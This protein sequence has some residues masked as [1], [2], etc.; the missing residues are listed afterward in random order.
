MATNSIQ[1]YSCA[2]VLPHL[3]VQNANAVSSPMTWG[4]PA[5]SAFAGFAHALERKLRADGK[6]VLLHGVAV[7]CHKAEPL[8]A[9]GP[10][11]A[12][13]GFR[14]T[15]NPLDQS[16]NTSAIVEEGR[17]HLTVSI[18]LTVF[19]PDAPRQEN[20]DAQAFAAHLLTLALGM[21]IA[22]GSVVP[23]GIA[24][25]KPRSARAF[26]WNS[27]SKEAVQKKLTRMLM[28]GFALIGRANLLAEHLSDLRETKA[29]ATA[30][31]ALLDLCALH[32][33]PA[34]ESNKDGKFSWTAKRRKKSGFLVPIPLGFAAI[35]ETYPPGAVKN[36]RDSTVPFRFVE[37]VLSLGEWRS[38]HRIT[39][40]E[41]MLWRYHAQ[42]E[43]G[44]YLITNSQAE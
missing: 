7:V 33:A 35:S 43:S 4:F 25:R 38:P 16:G 21:R 17:M 6:D 34:A 26:I 8:L 13:R 29:D 36:A 2:V 28:P 44:T 10:S 19:G 14:L 42:P 18:V 11:Y 22:G 9:D 32:I 31:D 23:P 3:Y 41:D 24:L 1:E 30:L 5:M 37:S 20:D 27:G 39:D 40:L 15:R 12:P